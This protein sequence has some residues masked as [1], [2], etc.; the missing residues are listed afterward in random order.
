M[1]LF[2]QNNKASANREEQQPDKI[3][4]T[5][6]GWLVR[7]AESDLAV[8][9][10][11]AAA[12]TQR[13]D[14]IKR[15]ETTLV[16]QI[17]ELQHQ[18]I[19]SREAE[20]NDLKSEIF[21]C[22][23]RIARLEGT[24]SAAD[25]AKEFVKE[26]GDLRKQFDARQTVLESHY[27]GFERLGETLETQMRS[28]EREL[29]D[30]LD[31]IQIA[32]G[33]MRHLQS[34]TQSLAERVVHAE[35][36]TWQARTLALRNAQQL[37]QTAESLRCEISALNAAF[38][39]L[40]EKQHKLRLPETLLNEVAQNLN[41][42]V[43]AIQNQ[44]A[45][46]HNTQLAWNARFRDLDADLAMLIERLANTE[47]LS[48]ETHA[49]LQAEVNSASDFRTKTAQELATLQGKL[50]DP[51]A[52]DQ[53]I[54]KLEFSL[55][56]I[57]EE[58]Q[59]Q[60][61][62]KFILLESRDV[63]QETRARELEATLT[64]KNVEQNALIDETLGLLASGQEELRRL[65][66]EIQTLV[67][68]IVHS[69]SGAQK[70]QAT[71]DA[72]ATRIGKLEDSL[73]SD[74]AVLN[75]EF[76]K[77]AD[78]QRT[79]R[80]PDEQLRE[81]ECKLGLKV[82]ELQQQL[83]LERE[84]FDHWG[85]GLREAFGAEL[86]A[87]QARLSER[88]SHIEHRYARL[89]RWEDTAKANLEMMEAQLKEN[90]KLEAHEHEEWH[91]LESQLKTL[92]ARTSELEF[93]ARQVVDSFAESSRETEQSIA[94]LR[95]KIYPLEPSLDHRS[96]PTYE[97]VIRDLEAKLDA[98]LYEFEEQFTQQL[99]L[100]DDSDRG[101]QSELTLSGFRNELSVLR[102]A[103]DDL[104]SALPRSL[105]LSPTI[106]ESLWTKIREIDQQLVERF[107]LI[108]SRAAEQARHADKSIETLEGDLAAIQTRINQCTKVPAES[109]MC[110]L[111]ESIRTKIEAFEQ[112]V[113][114]KL[115]QL[116][117]RDA[118]RAQEAEEFIAKLKSEMAAFNGELI[119]PP[120][121][122]SPAD[123]VLSGLENNLSAK[124]EE[125][126]QQMG[127]NFRAFDSREGDLRELKERSQS[128]I[129]RVTQLS[130][131]IQ[132]SQTTAAFAVPPIASRP[133][134]SALPAPALKAEGDDNPAEIQARSEKE[135]LIKLQE[136]MS[137]EIKRV[138]AELKERSGRWKVRR[139]AS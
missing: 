73:K 132:L 62:Q 95:N 48:D 97:S 130:A 21:A 70:A 16:G 137:S 71:A 6:F 31:S 123:P 55:R 3:K 90:L 28:L 1:E 89:E 43:T 111:E 34:E 94:V 119:Q 61:S 108:D 114:Q 102:T 45:Q 92:G 33:E 40:N 79:L 49:L 9:Q 91:R 46:E 124:I 56:N 110:N 53:A 64:A 36:A 107:T 30:K 136:R 121:S 98:R 103:V 120:V 37:E 101:R 118:E 32:P 112:H 82:D 58:W 8:A 93:R 54:Q 17:N 72:S 22:A 139:S 78:L 105:A 18:I 113:A 27:S 38:T 85:K 67:D 25:V 68:R 129:Q 125:L 81:I 99:S 76:A 86:S 59:R 44:V 51:S 109:M 128:L 7:R 65:K 13:A 84:D 60:A 117:K 80:L 131:A 15:L 14:Q 69:E 88:Q 74:I 2:D 96:L 66:P 115:I 126:R 23:D 83:T 122:I 12:E 24:Q 77:L 39:D 26:L 42:K 106:E 75:A 57:T 116:D 11:L 100:Y 52:Q 127:Q 50:G 135:Q 87:I 104:Q 47:S 20:L 29:Q 133:E 19:E 138:R 4:H 41:A 10:A 5:S 63:E 134:V 35:S